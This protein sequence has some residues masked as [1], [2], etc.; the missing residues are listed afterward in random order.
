MWIWC[1]LSRHNNLNVSD[2]INMVGD[3]KGGGH[4]IVF[5]CVTVPATVIQC[6]GLDVAQ[7]LTMSDASHPA[8]PAHNQPESWQLLGHGGSQWLEML[9]VY[10]VILCHLCPR[11]QSY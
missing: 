10:Y 2:T 5:L 9:P 6:S 8:G 7:L 4:C 3:E 11:T 1:P